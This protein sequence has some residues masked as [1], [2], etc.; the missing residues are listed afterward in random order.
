MNKRIKHIRNLL[1]LSQ[2]EFAENF[3]LTQSVYQKY[4]SGQRKVPNELLSGIISHF[5]FMSDWIMTGKG[6]M[7]NPDKIDSDK[8]WKRLNILRHRFLLFNG[9]Q[10]RISE[11]LNVGLDQYCKWEY[12]YETIPNSVI[13]QIY[14][15]VK[16]DVRKDWWYE[17]KGEMYNE[18]QTFR[19]EPP[20][21][22]DNNVTSV[23]E[24]IEALWK[25]NLSVPGRA[26]VFMMVNYLNKL[27][28]PIK[29]PD[30]KK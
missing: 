9:R 2:Q 6:D 24:L 11:M 10:E 20:P 3:N 29:P 14:S 17:G 1:S 16:P 12:A 7:V 23:Q 4:E 5:G 13:E 30:Q 15:L 8:M 21:D 19:Y 27:G 25:E 28:I 22:F 18:V 26:Y